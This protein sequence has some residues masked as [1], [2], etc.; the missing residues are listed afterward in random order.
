MLEMLASAHFHHLWK[1]IPCLWPIPTEYP[2]YTLPTC[3]PTQKICTFFGILVVN[4]LLSVTCSMLYCSRLQALCS[5]CHTPWKKC[6]NHYFSLGTLGNSDSDE[7]EDEPVCSTGG[8][9]SVEEQERRGSEVAQ[10]QHSTTGRHQCINAEQ[11]SKKKEEE[12][13]QPKAVCSW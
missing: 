8:E 11:N 5:K 2:L 6:S 10:G 13:I 1:R 4:Y 9:C 12:Y 3:M 7:T